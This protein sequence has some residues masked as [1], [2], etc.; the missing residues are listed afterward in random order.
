MKINIKSLKKP[1][2]TFEN[3]GPNALF[4][5]SYSKSQVWLK[6]PDQPS[7]HPYS[8]SVCLNDGFVG[9]F[10]PLDEVVPLEGEL[11]VWRKS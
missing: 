9:K 11:S 6:Y 3:I 7:Q 10:R 2:V 4:M 5:S 8:N 1:N